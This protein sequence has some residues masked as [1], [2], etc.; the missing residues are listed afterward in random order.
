LDADRREQISNSGIVNV[1]S[2]TVNAAGAAFGDRATVINTSVTE[3]AQAERHRSS[4]DRWDLGVITVLAEETAAMREM[5]GRHGGYTPAPRGMAPGCYEGRLGDGEHAVRVALIQTLEQ[6]QRSAMVALDRLRRTYDPAVVALVGIAGAIHDSLRRGDVV[7]A[8]EIIYYDS[9]KETAEGTIRRGHG[10]PVP[11]GVRHAVNAFFTGHG[12]PAMLKTPGTGG[13]GEPFAVHQGP[14]ASGEAVVASRRSG[15]PGYLSDFNDKVL[16]VEME[17][18]A[19]AQAFYEE[20]NPGAAANWLVIRGISDHADPQKNDLH[21]GTASGNAAAVLE[22][23]FPY[24][25]YDR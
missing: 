21:H 5:L 22:T 25:T 16:A 4:P 7:I 15:I 18:G 8:T 3:P 24:L 1:G 2:G 9:R 10:Y 11:P 12:E 17:G 23:I 14:I 13:A 19:P 6:G 20:L